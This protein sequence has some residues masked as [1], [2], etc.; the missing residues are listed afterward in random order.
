LLAS[1]LLW[2]AN[3]IVTGS[4]GGTIL[5]LANAT[6]NLSTMIRMARSQA[7]SLSPRDELVGA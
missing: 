4:I 7:T 2:L 5:E 1:T 3:D 6:I